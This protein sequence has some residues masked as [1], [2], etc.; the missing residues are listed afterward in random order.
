[1]RRSLLLS[2][3]A[4]CLAGSAT[5][6]F[7]LKNEWFQGKPDQFEA[8]KL[9]TAVWH[10]TDGQ[11][12]RFSTAGKVVRTFSGKVCAEKIAKVDGFELEP[13]DK[14]AIE[15]GG[16]CLTFTFTTDGGVDGFDF[17]AEGGG[18]TYDLQMDGKPIPRK[19]IFIG[20]GGIHPKREQ[21]VLDRT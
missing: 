4:A 12:V 1:M 14:V 3:V 21:F 8:G 13:E 11:H 10:D 6:A 17:Q 16:V 9:M 2:T 5:T 20:K 15:E 7:A 18:I 19:D